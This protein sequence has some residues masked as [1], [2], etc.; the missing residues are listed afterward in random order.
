MFKD[1]FIFT[2]FYS[3][4]THR[5]GFHQVN[6]HILM[7]PQYEN[8]RCTHQNLG[9]IKVFKLYPKHV[10]TWQ[11]VWKKKQGKMVMQFDRG[12]QNGYAV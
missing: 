7:G 11:K 3:F 4:I 1:S 5:D 2:L 10:S 8:K 9:A 12:T 6:I